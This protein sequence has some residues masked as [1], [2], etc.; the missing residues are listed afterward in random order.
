MQAA[1]LSGSVSGMLLNNIRCCCCCCKSGIHESL[2][3]WHFLARRK[4]GHFQ[5]D[6]ELCIACV[7]FFVPAFWCVVIITRFVFLAALFIIWHGMILNARKKNFLVLPW[8]WN[9]LSRGRI[10]FS[11]ALLRA[12]QI[13]IFFQ[14]CLLILVHGMFR[15]LFFFWSCAVVIDWF[16]GT[17]AQKYYFQFWCMWFFSFSVLVL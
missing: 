15:L 1:A 14:C 3:I 13:S 7:K 10:I 4:G 12:A 2:I 11:Y 17:A 5:W 16:F 6:C 9:L 8:T